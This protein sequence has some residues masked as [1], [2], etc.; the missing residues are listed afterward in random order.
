MVNANVVGYV[1]GAGGGGTVGMGCVVGS[2]SNSGS[3]GEMEENNTASVPPTPT[4]RF[5]GPDFNI[6]TLKGRMEEEKEKEAFIAR[7]F[8]VTICFLL[9]LFSLG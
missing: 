6:E 5:F 8:Q 3:N 4:Q 9:F 2:S 7:K 1:G